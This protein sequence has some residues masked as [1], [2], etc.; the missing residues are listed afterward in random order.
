MSREI[1]KKGEFFHYKWKGTGH[2]VHVL[3]TA[4][5]DDEVS[6]MTVGDQKNRDATPR[7]VRRAI[8]DQE[9][10]LMEDN[11][12]T[13]GCPSGMVWVEGYWKKNGER[14][15]GYCRRK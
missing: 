8:K 12:R 9:A 10:Y 11:L 5:P 3:N 6:Y 2:G 1:Y 14:V 13:V 15:R 4:N 7:E